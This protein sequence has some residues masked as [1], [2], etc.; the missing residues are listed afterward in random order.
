MPDCLLEMPD[1][2]V[3]AEYEGELYRMKVFE[4]KKET[5]VKHVEK[6]PSESKSH[7]PPADH[8]WRRWV[9]RPEKVMV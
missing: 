2:S 7:K 5:P 6:K 9:K 3:R 1:G 8:P 4:E